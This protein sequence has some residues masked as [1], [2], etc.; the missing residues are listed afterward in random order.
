MKKLSHLLLPIA[1]LIW[2]APPSPAAD[3]IDLPSQ[4]AAYP[5][6][7]DAID[8]YRLLTPY[9]DRTFRG[10]RAFTRYEMA[11]ALQHLLAYFTTD[12]GL[13]FSAEREG[14]LTYRGFL[15]ENGGDL[16]PRHWAATAIQQVVSYGWMSGYPDLT[17]RGQ[18]KVSRYELASQLK[19]VLDKLNIPAQGGSAAAYE[20]VL[21]NRG[22]DVPANHWSR[23]ALREVIARGLMASDERGRFRG[24]DPAS[25]YD[26]AIGLVSL[27]RLVE[28][29]K[30]QAS[31]KPS[32]RPS[33]M[34]R[35][36]R[37]DRFNGRS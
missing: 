23:D 30:P 25:Q 7:Q 27:A 22:G 21:S 35:P 15:Q 8:K 10:K 14:Y 13:R 11:K 20:R 24:N 6:V 37:A 34:P 5:F 3:L 9:P 2:I 26:L 33:V 17:F 4:H 29:A 12:M 19:R 18:N 28:G 16:I 31:P 36:V 32:A 1:F